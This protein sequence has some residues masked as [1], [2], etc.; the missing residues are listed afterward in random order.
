MLACVDGSGCGNLTQLHHREYVRRECARFDAQNWGHNT[1]IHHDSPK[2]LKSF[3]L[4]HLKIR[5]FVTTY[6][7]Q[8]RLVYAGLTSI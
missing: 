4:H 7:I 5:N 1:Y 2:S 6:R 3:L 8:E